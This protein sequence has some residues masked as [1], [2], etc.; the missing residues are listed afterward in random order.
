MIYLIMGK[1]GSGKTLFLTKIAKDEAK[2]GKTIY[3]NVA[4]KGIPYTP[5]N[6]DDII[7]CKYDNGVVL[8]DEIHLLL[9]SR[10][11]MSTTSRLLV[12]GFL[13]MVRKKNLEIYGSTQTYRKVDVRFR[14]E[15]EYLG[16]CT[17]YAYINGSYTEV[18]HNQNLPV[19]IPILVKLQLK[20]IESGAEMLL[21]FI[22]NSLFKHFNTRQ[23]I[24]I[25]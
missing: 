19:I 12:D 16:Y 5:I 1:Q 18:R 25:F 11:S 23:I 7:A 21:T 6:Y 17:K 4:F 22:A 14:E 20:E 8:L 3:S 2:K 13:S 15:A 24:K 10:N 9:P